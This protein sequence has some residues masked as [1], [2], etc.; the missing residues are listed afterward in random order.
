VHDGYVCLGELFQN[1][2]QSQ[3]MQAHLGDR[4]GGF[5]LNTKSPRLAYDA[6]GNQLETQFE[7]SPL[8]VGRRMIHRRARTWSS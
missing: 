8:P 5:V 1:T 2:F 4:K 6:N 7:T 3:V